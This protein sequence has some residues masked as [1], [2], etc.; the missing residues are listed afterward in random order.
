VR[1]EITQGLDVMVRFVNVD[2]H[3][4]VLFVPVRTMEWANRYSSALEIIFYKNRSTPNW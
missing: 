2:S 3:T 4:T 1:T